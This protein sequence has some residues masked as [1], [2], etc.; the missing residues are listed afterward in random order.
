M[1]FEGGYNW[2][3][4]TWMILL[5]FTVI[6]VIVFFVVW[7]VFKKSFLQSSCLFLNIEGTL[8]WV[9]SLSPEGGLPPPT[10]W[11]KRISWFFEFARGRSVAVNPKM[12]YCGIFFIIVSAIFQTLLQH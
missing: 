7:F 8:L 11:K 10:N 9:S 4:L 1:Q 5:I 6:F 3:P 12:L 2:R